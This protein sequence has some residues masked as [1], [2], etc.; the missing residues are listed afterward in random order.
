[1]CWLVWLWKEW[2]LCM[3]FK[4]YLLNKYE[5]LLKIEDLMLKYYF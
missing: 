2:W 4:E 5:K 1:M 3:I